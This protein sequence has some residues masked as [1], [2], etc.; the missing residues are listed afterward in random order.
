V[1]WGGKDGLLKNR[2]QKKATQK[3]STKKAGKR[4]GGKSEKVKGACVGAKAG[5]TSIRGKDDERNKTRKGS[6]FE[7]E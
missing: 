6:P 1:G 7:S 2:V 3:E 5:Q 4:A